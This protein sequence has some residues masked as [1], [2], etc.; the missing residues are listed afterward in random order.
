MLAKKQF[1]SKSKSTEQ[2]RISAK[3]SM[4]PHTLGIIFR[5]SEGNFLTCDFLPYIVRETISKFLTLA[6]VAVVYIRTYSG[7]CSRFNPW[8]ISWKF[9]NKRR[10]NLLLENLPASGFALID[11]RVFTRKCAPP[12]CHI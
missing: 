7:C 12:F 3:I 4:V 9:Y 10:E 8:R 1:G 5:E 2:L 6:L 11:N